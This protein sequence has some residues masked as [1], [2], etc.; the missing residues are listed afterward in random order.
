MDT[1]GP[2]HIDYYCMKAYQI[3]TDLL[4]FTAGECGFLYPM[5]FSLL[6]FK[7]LSVVTM[8]N[9]DKCINN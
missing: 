4:I 1:A 8:S 3:L 9:T 6:A 2:A 7:D 5:H